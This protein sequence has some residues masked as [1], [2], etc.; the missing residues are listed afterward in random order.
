MIAVT[1]IS[2]QKIFLGRR[3]PAVSEPVATSGFGSNV[4]YV[5]G[6]VATRVGVRPPSG[7]ALGGEEA[8]HDATPGTPLACD[9]VVN[10]SLKPG[11]KLGPFR[12]LRIL[13]QGAQG[14]VWKAKR[15][16]P[17]VEIVALKVLNPSLAA[18][19]WR[20][21][22]FRREAERGARMAGPSLLPVFEYGQVD[23]FVYMAMPFVEGTTLQEVIRQRRARLRGE[24]HVPVHRLIN[25]DDESYL[26]LAARIMAR[27]ARALADVHSNRVVHRDIKPANILLDAN[28]PHGVYLCDLG[29]GRD[30]EVATPEQMRDGAGTPMYMA[31]E[32]LLRAPA[33][34]V[35]CDI[36]SLGVTL[37]ET[38]T[39]TRPFRLPDGMPVAC[40]SAYLARTEPRRPS[41]VRPDLP[42]DLERLVRKAM[43]RDPADRYLSAKEL[44]A[45][46]DRFLVR[47][48]FHAR[49]SVAHPS[50]SAGAGPH[51]PIGPR[52]HANR[53][54]LPD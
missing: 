25:L 15:I 9:R 35:L 26:H 44:A 31:P 16:E 36:Y 7:P 13:G 32:R 5:V 20:L 14:D 52:A 42:V 33:D 30:L 37:F 24:D 34:E 47:S 41:E 43:A 3:R 50:P 53:P 39:L 19:P 12:L 51:M 17:W 48:S 4:T 46:L 29:L 8:V 21:A 10:T 22:Q 23:G 54:S 49:R 2:L 28:R 38:F 11:K 18:L 45:D 1:Q 40:L 6:S 27:A